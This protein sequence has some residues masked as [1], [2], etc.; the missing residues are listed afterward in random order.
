MLATDKIEKKSISLRQH[1]RWCALIRL[2][3]E[4]LDC[5]GVR[6]SAG[7]RLNQ[8]YIM[9]A[10][11]SDVQYSVCHETR[12]SVFHYNSGYNRFS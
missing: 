1:T 2:R 8:A 3:R 4:V 6:V 11:Y 10:Y 12:Q 5:V 9:D 7:K